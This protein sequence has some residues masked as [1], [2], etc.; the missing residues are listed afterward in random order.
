MMLS[1]RFVFLPMMVLI[2]SSDKSQVVGQPEPTASPTAT[3]VVSIPPTSYAAASSLPPSFVV[4]GM[5][6]DSI[7]FVRCENVVNATNDNLYR[8][9]TEQGNVTMSQNG[10]YYVPL[11]KAGLVIDETISIDP[12]NGAVLPIFDN[13]GPLRWV[14]TPFPEFLGSDT[15]Q[16]E[17]CIFDER[18]ENELVC[19]SLWS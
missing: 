19:V 9:A 6:P 17:Q 4:T 3:R 8:N 11:S 7:T 15:F 14:Y 10:A 2:Q 5:I 12:I 13:T 18:P 1:H 16:M